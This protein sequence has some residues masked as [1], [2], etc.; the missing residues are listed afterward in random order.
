MQSF[1]AGMEPPA[2]AALRDG[3]WTWAPDRALPELRLTVSAFVRD[4]DICFAGRCRPLRTLVK[5]QA[6]ADVVVMRT[7]PATSHTP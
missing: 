1:G 2:D 4:Y 3:W 5:S 6:E 7:C